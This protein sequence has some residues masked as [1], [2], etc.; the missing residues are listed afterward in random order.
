MLSRTIR[1]SVDSFAA[2]IGLLDAMQRRLQGRFT[3]LMYHRVLP[4][5]MCHLYPMTNLVVPLSVFEAQVAWLA[6]HA[7]IC[8]VGEAIR[9]SWEATNRVR[10]CV[11]FD[12]G[13]WDNAEV[14]APVLDRAG[15]RS[16]F[17]IATDFVDQGVPLW[18]DVAGLAWIQERAL[19][20]QVASSVLGSVPGSLEEWLGALKADAAARDAAVS[21]LKDRATA[22][23][24]PAI[25]RAMTSEQAS[26]LAKR[27]H[28][29]G[30]HSRS[31]PILTQLD[32]ERL[33][34]EITGSL[35]IVQSWSKQEATGFAYPNGS[36]DERVRSATR[37]G[38]AS[39]AVTTLRGCCGRD[40]DRFSLMRRAVYPASVAKSGVHD[41]NAFQ[42]EL[43][44]LHDAQRAVLRRVGRSLN[45]ST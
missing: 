41:A 18:F 31:H 19:A 16:T 42:A 24:Q 45:A 11:S 4:D 13:Y 1:Q 17:Y 10:V 5:A 29:L 26:Q 38:G 43:V 37:A 32:D 44:G 12:D 34:D 2:R 9:A 3:I 35:A 21:M 6:Q 20:V 14:A 7:E 33:H 22:D 27:G 8:T 30:A 28:E 23:L 15:L 40:Q 25:N 39:H 36:F